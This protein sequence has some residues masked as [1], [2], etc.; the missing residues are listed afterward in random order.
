[1]PRAS[2]P[3]GAPRGALA[4][5]G[6]AAARERL[7]VLFLVPFP[8][9]TDARLGGARAAAHIIAA[10]AARHDV[11]VLYL[12]A[13]REEA[14]DPALRA[15]C[16]LVEELRLP[17]S[18]ALARVAHRAG[19]AARQARGMPY[20]PASVGSARVAT[21]I[22]R[23]VR[24]WRP[25]V[26][27]LE[28]LPMGQFADTARE[29]G[30]AVVLA[31]YDS[32]AE[33][34][35]EELASTHRLKRAVAALQLARWRRYERSIVRRADAVVTFTP[36]DRAVYERAADG[37]TPVAEVA[38]RSP[39][40]ERAL[41]AVGASPPEVL[42]VGNFVH[43]PNVDAA[44]RL[45]RAIAPLVW[46]QVPGARL[47]IVGHEP[48]HVLRA[49]ASERVTVTGTV[50]AVEPWL[51]RAAV[52]AVPLRLGGGMRVKVLEALAAGKAVVASPRALEGLAVRDGVE[53][54]VAD[55]AG[56]VAEAIVA[57]LRAPEE[58][59]AMGARAREWARAA[60]DPARWTDEYD[61]LYRR[62]LAGDVHR[63]SAR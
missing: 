16:R 1:V 23:L 40:P 47:T 58:R 15:A 41:D 29:G 26:V 18:S 46:A 21:H 25:D 37:A 10:H 38:L 34:A 20:W 12:S 36:R 28:C 50:P 6:D 3:A 61:A 60:L 17:P 24:E 4:P 53:A 49:L 27:R 22:R 56:D 14:I 45:V 33:A 19:I 52:V 43:P 7:R 39:V 35:S 62:L 55:D 42:F 9:R 54:R 31:A 44:L 57:L 59:V 13:P 11:A 63:A 51:A 32:F 48:P 8:P 30:A 2:S 5:A